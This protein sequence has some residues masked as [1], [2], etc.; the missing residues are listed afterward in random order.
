MARRRGLGKHSLPFD[1]S[2]LEARRR[3]ER[4]SDESVVSTDCL[5]RIRQDTELQHDRNGMRP[6]GKMA[7]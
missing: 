1:L 2:P 5:S 4:V 3:A 6:N 7:N